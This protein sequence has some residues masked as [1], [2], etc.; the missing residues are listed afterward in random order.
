MQ[1]S[2]SSS[3][4]WSALALY[5]TTCRHPL[6]LLILVRSRRT[7]LVLKVHILGQ[8]WN[9]L[10]QKQQSPLAPRDFRGPSEVAPE[11]SSPVCSEKSTSLPAFP[12]KPWC[13]LVNTWFICSKLNRLSMSYSHFNRRIL[14]YRELHIWSKEKHIYVHPCTPAVVNLFLCMWDYNRKWNE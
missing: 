12:M 11:H 10:E 13:K 2:I 4:A 3:L 7:K 9:L 14:N 5:K 1:Q 8:L 6:L